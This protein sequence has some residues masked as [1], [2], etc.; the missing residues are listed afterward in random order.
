MVLS[1]TAYFESRQNEKSLDKRLEKLEKLSFKGS[2][3]SHSV[4]AE[5]MDRL[6]KS[7]WTTNKLADMLA[8]LDPAFRRKLQEIDSTD[9]Y[10]RAKATT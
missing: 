1:R 2:K 7:Y 9:E 3:I 4:H 6:K 10:I 8:K 5:L